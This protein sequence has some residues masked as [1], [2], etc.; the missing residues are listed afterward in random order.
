ME[1]KVWHFFKHKTSIP[2]VRA[3]QTILSQPFYGKSFGYSIFVA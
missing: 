3:L 2:E 1:K